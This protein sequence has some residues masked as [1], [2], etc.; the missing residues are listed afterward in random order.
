MF[1]GRFANGHFSST[2]N[3]IHEVVRS[4]NNNDPCV[5]EF[6]SIVTPV[7]NENWFGRMTNEDPTSTK[8]GT[9]NDDG[10]KNK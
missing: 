6:K 4:W 3:P 8:K 10:P 9:N 2:S 1:K 7:M 5:S